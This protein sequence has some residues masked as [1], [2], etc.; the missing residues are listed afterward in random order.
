MTGY[1]LPARTTGRTDPFFQ[2]AIPNGVAF[3]VSVRSSC[4]FMQAVRSVRMGRSARAENRQ[5]YVSQ[6]F[7][8]QSHLR[9]PARRRSAAVRGDCRHSWHDDLAYSDDLGRPKR[10]GRELDVSAGVGS[11]DDQGVA[12]V[13]ADVARGT[14][15][16]RI[17]ALGEDQVSWG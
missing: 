8:C 9:R 16:P 17:G 6:N 14:A 5:R 3:C 1:T 11:V 4:I 10:Q 15:G 13:H 12:D 2:K 7:P